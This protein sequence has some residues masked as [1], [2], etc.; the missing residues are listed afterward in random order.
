[1]K[2]PCSRARRA[3]FP[4]LGGALPSLPVFLTGDRMKRVI[5]LFVDGK[6]LATLTE[7]QA[8]EMKRRLLHSKG[9]E[10]REKFIPTKKGE[11]A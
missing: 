10:F 11:R 7:N 3:A 5:E 4:P 2:S 9:V 8:R 1:M 6:K